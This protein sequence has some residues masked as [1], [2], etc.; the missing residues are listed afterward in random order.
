MHRKIY[1]LFVL[2]TLL[3][4]GDLRAQKLYTG[5]WK[6]SNE[7][8]YLWGGVNWK[9]FNDKWD[10]LAKK[11]LRLVNI[12]TYGSGS[13]R[14]FT[15]V[16]LAGNDAYALTPAGLDWIAFNKFW[17]DNSKHGLRLINVETYVEGGILRF[18]GIFRAG[19]DAY[20]LTPF[21]LD[22]A[23][24]NKFW[25][26]AAKQNLRLV[27][28][29]SYLSGGKRCFL[30]VFRGGKDGYVLS[31][32]GMDWSAFVQ[33][34]N[35]QSPALR[36]IDVE[37]FIDNGKRIYLGA[38]REGKGGYYLW[39]G[40]DWES[41]T[42][43]WAENASV[44]MRLTDLETFDSNCPG[45][46]LNTGL[47]PDDPGTEWRDGYDY[48][49]TASATHYQGKP[50]TGKKSDETVVYYR[51]PNLQIGTQYY[52]RNSVIFDAKDQIFTLPFKVKS[53]E[54][55]HNGW[56]YDNGG[57]HHAIDYSRSGMKTFEVCA[58]A[59]GKVIHVGWDTWSGGTVV[60][61]HDVGGKK[62]VYRTIYMHL[63]NGP[64]NDCEKAW[65][66][67]V[68]TLQTSSN[69]SDNHKKNYQDYLNETGC[70]QK[71]SDRDPKSDWWGTSSQAI[72]SSL[73]GKTVAAGDV[74]AWAGSTG[75]G[76]CGCVNGGDGPNTHLHIFFAHRDPAND[77]WY[78]FDPYG[79]YGYGDC[80]PAP[81]D[82]GNNNGC[83]RYPVA[84]KNGKPSYAD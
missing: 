54:M 45:K 79:V 7:G 4:Y 16:W 26:D 5:I 10:E 47:L 66:L 32:Y 8:Y 75:P 60:I 76:G 31:P 71:K 34:W 82:A 27:N 3:L 49:V 64:D 56:R 17:A 67:T 2:L 57:W 36:L 29:E 24:F 6:Q 44:G 59:P 78:L 15:G 73:L 68:P 46:C 21:G 25:S 35:K 22:W 77:L 65:T 28:I 53:S 51:W 55:Y 39:G 52:L 18:L 72:S 1:L 81:V 14:L 11:N 37:T 83:N 61:S 70:P 43:K 20:A 62:D 50:G 74:I 69:P 42:S 84:W 19:N 33:Y 48:G 80:Y 13:Q 30:G 58:A 63:R 41:F 9:D 40:T 12:K 23:A 38:W